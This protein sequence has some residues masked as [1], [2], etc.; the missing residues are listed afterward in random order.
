MDLDLRQVGVGGSGLEGLKG[1]EGLEGWGEIG[2]WLTPT[3][4]LGGDLLLE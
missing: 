1:L 4:D 2:S 3:Q